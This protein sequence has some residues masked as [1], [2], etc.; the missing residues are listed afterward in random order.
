MKMNGLNN[1][2]IKE[3]I[4]SNSISIK[5]DT[6]EKK[7]NNINQEL[8]PLSMLSNDETISTN[9]NLLS[10]NK[11]NS[12]ID[13]PFSTKS[14]NQFKR[15]IKIPF[16]I[17]NNGNLQRKKTLSKQ[18]INDQMIPIKIKNFDKINDLPSLFEL[19]KNN[20]ENKEIQ[21]SNNNSYRRSSNNHILS[22]RNI[23]IN[24][25]TT[26]DENITSE[27]NI[28]YF[29]K[30]E[31]NYSK[32]TQRSYNDD[33]LIKIKPKC[34]ICNKLYPYRDIIY[35]KSCKH[36]F[37]CE[38]IKQYF[39]NLILKGETDILNFKCPVP[40]C[41]GVYS[42]E[43]INE[44]IPIPYLEYLKDKKNNPMNYSIN[45]LNELNKKSD[46][47]L[48]SIL[49]EY[50][51]KNVLNIDSNKI[52][53]LY[54]KNKNN[55]CPKCFK[56]SLFS[57]KGKKYKVCLLCRKKFCKFCQNEYSNFHF[58]KGYPDYCKIY[59][60]L[61]DNDYSKNEIGFC[62]KFVIS[63]IYKIIGILIIYFGF[64]KF[65]NRQLKKC[66]FYNE[67][68]I[69]KNNDFCLFFLIKIVIYIILVTIF[70]FALFALV[71]LI[72]PYFPLISLLDFY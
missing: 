46:N 16:T 36:I 38:C 65:I 67:N 57:K 7:I 63:L 47:K 51:K 1:E 50:S 40:N 4:K 10:S 55:I 35:S 26:R 42:K 62:S 39:I 18:I 59:F 72:I 3:K 44:N 21:L 30:N 23:D 8:H 69:L 32:I 64:G 53:Y 56:N 9:N 24:M 68:Y 28:N 17:D 66:F 29:N 52:F 43:I 48:N 22:T 58:E 33:E 11:I 31:N 12:K 34:I 71:I 14:T 45:K 15:R 54:S 5:S 6:N 13:F 61:N 2:N 27:N 49:D 25:M 41:N 70:Y 20:L 19:E 60:K 37:C